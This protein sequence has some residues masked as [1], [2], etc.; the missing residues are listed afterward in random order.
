[1]EAVKERLQDSSLVSW[2]PLM[3]FERRRSRQQSTAFCEAAPAF[4]I[5]ELRLSRRP[6]LG[7]IDKNIEFRGLQKQLNLQELAPLRSGAVNQI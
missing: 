7:A 2:R 6:R 3:G 1:M 5:P 4:L